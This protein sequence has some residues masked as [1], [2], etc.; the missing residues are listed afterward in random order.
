MHV[1]DVTCYGSDLVRWLAATTRPAPNRTKHVSSASQI[2]DVRQPKRD[3]PQ[4]KRSRVNDSTAQS[5]RQGMNTNRTTQRRRNSSAKHVKDRSGC[6]IA[7]R[8]EQTRQTPSSMHPRLGQPIRGPLTRPDTSSKL[9]ASHETA[10]CIDSEI[11]SR[12]KTTTDQQATAPYQGS[13]KRLPT[14]TY[15]ITSAH[16]DYLAC[17]SRTLGRPYVVSA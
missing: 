5:D 15:S 12:S 8:V 17:R 4:N 14:H 10:C 6:A 1:G 7:V 9:Q 3:E 16:R 11:I 13:C 2:R